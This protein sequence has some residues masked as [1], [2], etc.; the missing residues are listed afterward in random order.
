MSRRSVRVLAPLVG[1]VVGLFA[2]SAMGGI[3]GVVG[4]TG[5]VTQIAMPPASLALNQYES[6][7]QARLLQEQDDLLL[8]AALGVNITVPGLVDANGDLTPGS[9]SAGEIVDVYLL[10]VD[11]K[12]SDS[13]TTEGSITF[14]R[15]V[16]GLIVLTEGLDGSDAAVGI[17][18]VGYGGSTL[19]GLELAANGDRIALS[20]NRRTVTFRF[21]TSS[22]LD[23][24]R[25][26]I[27]SP[28]TCVM[29]L[30]ALAA[31]RRRRR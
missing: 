2:A 28:G 18:G 25:I 7:S 10:H 21:T 29:A 19:R 26:I 13:I 24:I 4:T 9:I 11:P 14:D 3:S 12:N 27:P 16:L 17:S 31:V 5:A 23:E 22:A 15:P 6:N 8:A 30:P 1:G 20:A